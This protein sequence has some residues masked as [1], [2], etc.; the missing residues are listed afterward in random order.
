MANATIIET[1][2]GLTGEPLRGKLPTGVA[3]FAIAAVLLV[4][5]GIFATDYWY[6]AILIPF[7]IMALA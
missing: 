3:G 6:D 7:L 1:T 4:V 5:A 2:T